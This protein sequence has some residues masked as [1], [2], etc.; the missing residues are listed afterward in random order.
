[1]DLQG[2]EKGVINTV[3]YNREKRGF[4]LEQNSQLKLTN[5][6]ILAICKILLDSRA[7]TKSD[8]SSMLNKMIDN[9]VPL[10]NQRTIKKLITNEE[11]HYIEPRHKKNFIGI[12]WEIGQAI[13]S[14]HYIEI[15]YQGL[16]GGLK[17]RKIKPAAII[18]SEMY[19]YMAAFHEDKDIIE[20]FNVMNDAFPTIYRIDR[21]HS[22]KILDEHFYVPYANRFEEGEYRKRI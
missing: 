20:H 17:T 9:C 6:E 21:I 16:Q 3:I 12:M 1:M 2:A 7:F 8:M 13:C 10:E 14:N 15:D 11:F 22:L 5:P 4:C 19:F 18:F